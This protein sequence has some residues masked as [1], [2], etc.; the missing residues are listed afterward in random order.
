MQELDCLQHII[1]YCIIVTHWQSLLL[2]L[3]AALINGSVVS[4]I[5]HSCFCIYNRTNVLR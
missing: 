4:R 1:S 2:L 3:A 5:L